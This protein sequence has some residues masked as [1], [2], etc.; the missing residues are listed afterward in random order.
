MYI[1]IYIFNFCHTVASTHDCELLDTFQDLINNNQFAEFWTTEYGDAAQSRE[2]FDWLDIE[3]SGFLLAEEWT[4]WFSLL[5]VD[6]SYV[7]RMK[8]YRPVSAVNIYMP[9][10]SNKHA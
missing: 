6:G 4:L 8:N 9:S 7:H 3:R 2:V 1:H 10:M 5:D